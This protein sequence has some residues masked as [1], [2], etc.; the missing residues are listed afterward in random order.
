MNLF[1]SLGNNSFT[2][3][4]GHR[5]PMRPNPLKQVGSGQERLL[6]VITMGRVKHS[7]T[8]PSAGHMPSRNQDGGRDVDA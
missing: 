6:P 5:L 3:S 4:I 1:A 7:R 8:D 2:Y